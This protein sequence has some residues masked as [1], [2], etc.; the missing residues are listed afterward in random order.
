[1]N[2]LSNNNVEI[3]RKYLLELSDKDAKLL[4]EIGYRKI[5][6]DENFLI[7]YAVI[8]IIEDFLLSIFTTYI[9]EKNDSEGNQLPND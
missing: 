4:K 1:M 3:F 6:E 8:K 2:I 5:K 9:N 7:E